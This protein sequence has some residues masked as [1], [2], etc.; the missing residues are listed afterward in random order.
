MAAR[1]LY[2]IGLVVL[3]TVVAEEDIMDDAADAVTECNF[4]CKTQAW[5]TTAVSWVGVAQRWQLLLMILIVACF[6]AWSAYF[7]AFAPLK[8]RA[9]KQCKDKVRTDTDAP[10]KDLIFEEPPELEFETESCAEDSTQAE[11]KQLQ[12]DKS[13]KLPLLL[14]RGNVQYPREGT[15]AKY[16]GLDAVHDAMDARRQRDMAEV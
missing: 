10:Q 16:G 11:E 3:S 8:I 13:E 12:C 4:Y 14:Y 1:V 7:G 15:V 5:T 2:I 9:W 6:I